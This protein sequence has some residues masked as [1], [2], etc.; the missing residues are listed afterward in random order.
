M[1]ALMI[2]IQFMGLVFSFYMY[3]QAATKNGP[4]RFMWLWAFVTPL[5]GI[6]LYVTVRRHL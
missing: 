4:R 5:W 3:T 2:P 6:L 1:S